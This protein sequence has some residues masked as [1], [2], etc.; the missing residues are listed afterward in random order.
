V[1]W[2]RRVLREG[3]FLKTRVAFKALGSEVTEYRGFVITRFFALASSAVS[4][5]GGGFL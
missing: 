2:K 1:V 3:G 4:P 5:P